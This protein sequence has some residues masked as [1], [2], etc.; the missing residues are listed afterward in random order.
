MGL[1]KKMPKNSTY[2][3]IF[4]LV[5]PSLPKGKPP[6]PPKGGLGKEPYAFCILSFGRSMDTYLFFLLPLQKKET[7]KSRP[8]T[9]TPRFRRVFQFGFCSAVVKGNSSLMALTWFEEVEYAGVILSFSEI[10]KFAYKRPK[11]LM[12]KPQ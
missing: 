3:S 4:L 11:K 7:K 5:K 9:V 1:F 10:D 2:T 8:K 12:Q 6:S